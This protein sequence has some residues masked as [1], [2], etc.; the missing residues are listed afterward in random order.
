MKVTENKVEIL[1]NK[2]TIYN[3]IS[4]F[5]VATS[6]EIYNICSENEI[7]I[8]DLI[9]KIAREM[10]WSGKITYVKNRKSDVYRHR[11]CSKN[12]KLLIFNLLT[13]ISCKRNNKLL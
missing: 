9:L 8:K 10:S 3:L 2:D 7:N 1:F 6:G 13:L 11:G 5:P 12:K 4:L